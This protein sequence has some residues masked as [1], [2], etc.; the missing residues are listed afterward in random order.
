MHDSSEWQDGMPAWLAEAFNGST[1]KGSS[2]LRRSTPPSSDLGLNRDYLAYSLGLFSNPPAT[3]V[4]APKLYA[5]SLR[6]P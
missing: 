6:S 3:V 1:N 5:A 4:A 2:S